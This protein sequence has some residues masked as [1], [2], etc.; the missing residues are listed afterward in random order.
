MYASTQ[1]EPAPSFVLAE[2]LMR[3]QDW[4]EITDWCYG[5]EMFLKHCQPKGRSSLLVFKFST[6]PTASL[7]EKPQTVSV[8]TYT[9]D[10]ISLISLTLITLPNILT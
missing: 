3:S 5:D 1:L 10:P 7:S 2:R 9:S 8:C 4:C 6:P